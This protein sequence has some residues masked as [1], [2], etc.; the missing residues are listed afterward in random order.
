MKRSFIYAAEKMSLQL[1]SSR[2]QGL[3]DSGK[4]YIYIFNSLSERAILPFKSF[5]RATDT[6]YRASS[7]ELASV[8]IFFCVSAIIRRASCLFFQVIE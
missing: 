7:G 4:E 8:D 1:K 3:I 6:S 2:R 5:S